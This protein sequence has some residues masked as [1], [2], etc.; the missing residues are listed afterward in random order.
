MKRKE[1]KNLAE[2]I[3]KYEYIIQNSNDEKAIQ[4]AQVEIMHLSNR[5]HDFQDL[6]IIDE[7]VQEILCKQS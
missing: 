5:V 6:D 7:M 3:A 4:T 1:L 2:K